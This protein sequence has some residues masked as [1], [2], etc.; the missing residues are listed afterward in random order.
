MQPRARRSLVQDILND[1]NTAAPSK[2]GPDPK[3]SSVKSPEAGKD[4][5]K[6]SDPYVQKADDLDEPVEPTGPRDA[7]V[8][9]EAVSDLEYMRRRMKRTLADV[10]SDADQKEKVWEQDEEDQDAP[11]V[12][13]AEEGPEEARIVDTPAEED[14]DAAVVL[15]T[16][17]LFVRNLPF[18]ALSKELEELFATCGEVS[19]VSPY[20]ALLHYPLAWWRK[21]DWRVVRRKQ[22]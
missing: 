6:P 13:Q 15:S 9:D 4:V 19:Q 5:S 7:L 12:G 2:A 20:F 14:A 8:N 21:M 1:S 16:G 22:R 10:G 17:R 11:E 3:V 18:K